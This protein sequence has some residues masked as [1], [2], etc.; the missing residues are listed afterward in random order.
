MLVLVKA[1][2]AALDVRL[3]V[4]NEKADGE[5]VLIGLSDPVKDIGGTRIALGLGWGKGKSDGVIGIV[6]KKVAMDA[7]N[8]T[9]VVG[10][11]IVVILA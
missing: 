8:G 9:Q 11:S 10:C 3:I 2:Q 7:E 6:T 4:V 1:I 5:I